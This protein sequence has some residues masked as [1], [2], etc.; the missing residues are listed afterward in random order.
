MISVIGLALST[1]LFAIDIVRRVSTITRLSVI[2]LAFSIFFL[3]WI[4]RENAIGS[5]FACD[6]CRIPPAPQTQKTPVD[7]TKTE[8]LI[9]V[10]VGT[11]QTDPFAGPPYNLPDI[12]IDKPQ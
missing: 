10:W 2:G 11:G 6:T 5:R 3:G 12:A 1:T 7:G 9:P 8:G 4:A